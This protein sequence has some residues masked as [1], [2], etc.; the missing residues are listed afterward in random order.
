MG[1][2]LVYVFVHLVSSSTIPPPNSVILP[3]NGPLSAEQ[4]TATSSSIN[5]VLLEAGKE[6]GQKEEVPV[7]AREQTQ[8]EKENVNTKEEEEKDKSNG[9]KNE[10]DN[11]KVDDNKKIN[12]ST[13]ENKK[14]NEKENAAGTKETEG[15]EETGNTNTGIKDNTPESYSN[16]TVRR[17]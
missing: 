15:K 6:K 5:P 13:K 9:N 7:T 4:P 2:F 1:F 11:K 16:S 8:E 14:E 3:K 10:K 17:V 12:D